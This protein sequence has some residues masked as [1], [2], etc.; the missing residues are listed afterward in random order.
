MFSCSGLQKEGHIIDPETGSP[1]TGRAACWVRLPESAALA[2]ALSTAGM[3]MTLSGLRNVSAQFSDM[4]LMLL[5]D[6]ADSEKGKLV[7]IG[8]WPEN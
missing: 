6:P 4:S 2:D 3:I 8:Q 5:L 7:K 1:L